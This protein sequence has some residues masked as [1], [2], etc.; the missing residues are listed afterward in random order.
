MLFSTCCRAAS[1]PDGA[2]AWAEAFALTRFS[3][4]SVAVDSCGKEGPELPIGPGEGARRVVSIVVSI[5]GPAK[6][7]APAWW[8]W[9]SKRGVVPDVPLRLETPSGA[10]APDIVEYLVLH[11]GFEKSGFLT[12]AWLVLL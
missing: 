9:G 12:L 4:S 1:H 3:I 5:G 11:E 2:S 7:V 10:G 6:A 8:P